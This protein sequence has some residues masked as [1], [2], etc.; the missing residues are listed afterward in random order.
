[1]SRHT[2]SIPLSKVLEE[3]SLDD[4]CWEYSQVIAVTAGQTIGSDYHTEVYNHLASL[5]EELEPYSGH[6]ALSALSLV[7]VLFGT[8]GVPVPVKDASD[9]D[10]SFTKAVVEMA[11]AVYAVLFHYTA[12]GEDFLYDNEQEGL[13]STIEFSFDALPT[14]EGRS[15]DADVESV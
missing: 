3:V 5:Y 9:I 1:M 10:G 6:I 11:S 14:G 7:K 4:L 2:V 8:A 15:K 13:P 12:S